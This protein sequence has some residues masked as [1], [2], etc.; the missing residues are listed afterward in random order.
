MKRRT[1]GELASELAH[2]ALDFL[3]P[4]LSK[5]SGA[6]NQLFMALFEK[7]MEIV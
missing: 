7:F 4:Q 5:T 1:K 3:I 2:F 6:Y